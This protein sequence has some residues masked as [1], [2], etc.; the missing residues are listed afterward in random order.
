[1]LPIVISLL[2]GVLKILFI[3]QKRKQRYLAV[4]F[5]MIEVIPPGSVAL[6]EANLQTR[7]YVRYL[8]IQ[9]KWNINEFIYFKDSG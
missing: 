3:A 8:S 6:V 7:L 9:I 4:I 2:Q 5:C 1:M